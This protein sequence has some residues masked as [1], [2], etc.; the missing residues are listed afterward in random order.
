MAVFVDRG[1]DRRRR[2]EKL[3]NLTTSTGESKRIEIC[4]W[5]AAPE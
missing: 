2:F 4:R 1:F 5:L 3:S